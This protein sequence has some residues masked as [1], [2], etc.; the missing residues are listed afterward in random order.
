MGFATRSLVGLL[1]ALGGGAAGGIV[2]ALVGIAITKAANVP[3]RE[4]AAG[5]A[6]LAAALIGVVVGVVV[7]IMLY[8]RSAPA[9]QAAS[10]AGSS[11]LGVVGLVAAVA[12][13]L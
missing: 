9:G 11:A 1:W 6:M 5:Y 10:Y 8:G 13:G 12:L 7:G 3:D 4:G 2:G